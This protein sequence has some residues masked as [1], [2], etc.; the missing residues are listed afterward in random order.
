M[1]ALGRAADIYGAVGDGSSLRHRFNLEEAIL[2]HYRIPAPARIKFRVIAPE[3]GEISGR[4]SVLKS[5]SAIARPNDGDGKRSVGSLFRCD[6]QGSLSDRGVGRNCD[7]IGEASAG[8][9]VAV[10][11]DDG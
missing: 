1:T 7:A 6:G 2:L 5:R 4:Y 9:L 10:E 8:R 11:V 3:L